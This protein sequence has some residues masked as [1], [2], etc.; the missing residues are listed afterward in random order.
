MQELVMLNANVSGW[1][2]GLIGTESSDNEEKG[3]TQ[4]TV[5][6]MTESQELVNMLGA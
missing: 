6:R 4:Q 5:V 2:R 3:V 1:F